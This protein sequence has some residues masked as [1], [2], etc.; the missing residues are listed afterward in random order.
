M[1]DVEIKTL[2]DIQVSKRKRVEKDANVVECFKQKYI[3]VE[4]EES[5]VDHIFDLKWNGFMYEGKF[6]DM[7]IT[8]QYKAERDFSA[9][10]V[11]KHTGTVQEP[12]KIQRKSSGYPN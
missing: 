6:L 7:T 10:K 3:K 2:L 5:G 12:I 1:A 9:E 8:C 11:Y 4:L